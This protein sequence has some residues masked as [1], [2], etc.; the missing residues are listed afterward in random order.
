MQFGVDGAETLVGPAMF[1]VPFDAVALLGAEFFQFVPK[2]DDLRF[3]AVDLA[4][5]AVDVVEDR[6]LVPAAVAAQLGEWSEPLK[7]FLSVLEPV[8]GVAELLLGV[9]EGELRLTDGRA[10]VGRSLA[11]EET[12]FG[13]LVEELLDTRGVVDGEAGVGFPAKGVEDF[14]FGCALVGQDA[15]VVDVGEAADIPGVGGVSAAA[16]GGVAGEPFEGGGAEE[17]DLRPGAALDTVDRAGPR[18]GAVGAAVGAVTLDERPL[19]LNGSAVAG[20]GVQTVVGDGGDGDDAPVVEPL[21]IGVDG[22]V[23]E[24]PVAGGVAPFPG[25]P[26]R[27]GE[28]GAVDLSA[29]PE[30]GA[31]AVGDVLAVGMGDGEGDDTGGAVARGSAT[32]ASARASRVACGEPRSCSTRGS[33]GWPGCWRRA[34]SGSG[35]GPVVPQARAGAGS[36]SG[37]GLGSC[38]WPRGER[39]PGRGHR[40]GRTEPG[41]D[42]RGTRAWRR[43]WRRR[44]PG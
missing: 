40:P 34:R 5:E 4:G 10:H 16:L 1:G 22:A 8:V 44:R 11:E 21:P 20:Q 27:P 38:R 31:D 6:R 41:G 3:G 24:E 17:V 18:V 39:V 19:E 42:R 30:A 9:L 29:G 26:R 23:D 32:T 2:A 36:P 14:L 35:P 13:L 12:K 43:G 7:T 33:C 28:F 37:L 15:A 25:A